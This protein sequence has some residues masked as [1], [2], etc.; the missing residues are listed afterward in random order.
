MQEGIAW[1]SARARRHPT[2]H[3][4][5]LPCRT[6]PAPL[7]WCQLDVRMTLSVERLGARRCRQT[8][9]GHVNVQLL[10]VGRVVEGIVRD[11]LV[12]TYK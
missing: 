3:I 4:A 7:S 12:S 9:E 10:G 2:K 11:S 8:L 6:P 5:S 1:G